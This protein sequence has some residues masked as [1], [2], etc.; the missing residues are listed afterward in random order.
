MVSF[1]PAGVMR[2]EHQHFET[3][4]QRIQ[5]RLRKSESTDGLGQELIRGMTAHNEKEETVLHPWID[6]LL[7][8]TEA[9]K[10][11]DQM[12]AALLEGPS[13]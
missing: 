4:L 12:K 11:V 5:D 7:S 2:A 9:Q 6:D 3:M 13:S 10:L 1:G 8:D